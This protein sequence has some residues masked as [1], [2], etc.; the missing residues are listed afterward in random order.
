[1]HAV[2]MM[3][4][5]F[6]EMEARGALGLLFLAS[7]VCGMA[8]IF[9]P[10]ILPWHAAIMPVLIL[11]TQLSILHAV[12]FTIVRS[13]AENNSWRDFKTSI[14]LPSIKSALIVDIFVFTIVSIGLWMKKGHNT[15]HFRMAG[16][17]E[18]QCMNHYELLKPVYDF[19]WS[20][21]RFRA[22]FRKSITYVAVAGNDLHATISFLR[23][24][25]ALYFFH[26][27]RT[28]KVSPHILPEMLRTILQTPAVWEQDTTEVFIEINERFA[29]EAHL[30]SEVHFNPASPPN[31][32]TNYEM[33][34]YETWT[35]FNQSQAFFTA[36]R[37]DL[38]QTNWNP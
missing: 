28:D 17:D 16:K 2:A 4:P 5:F 33:H 31:A 12:D 37:L 26:F 19:D 30:L 27:F 23:I 9:W 34:N 3:I 25:K 14:A 11:A 20:Y 36:S 13:M 38:F 8:S 24:G 15:L 32:V 21:S 22:L 35:P 7:V 18:E 10:S 6:I 1:M 29:E